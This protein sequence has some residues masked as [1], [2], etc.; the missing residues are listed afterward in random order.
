MKK[1]Q[2]T[3]TEAIA[4]VVRWTVAGIFLLIIATPAVISIISSA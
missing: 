3:L 1:A 4:H 2:T